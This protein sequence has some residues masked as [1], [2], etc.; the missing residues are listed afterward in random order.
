MFDA[1]SSTPP[2]N[3]ADPEKDQIAQLALDYLD[4]L[5]GSKDVLP[6][7]DSLDATLQQ[8]VLEAWNN[9]DRL[10]VDE[11]LPPLSD[12]PIALALGAVP[13]VL[14]DPRAL[15]KARQARSRRPSSIA[16]SLQQCGWSTTT[17]D[18]F[19]WEQR[20]EQ[21]ALALLAD[22]AAT[23]NVSSEAL[24]H[25]GTDSPGAME[26]LRLDDSMNPFLQVLYSDELNEIVDQWARLQG[27]SPRAA[28]DDLH[29]R[30]NAAAHRG[31]QTLTTRQWKAV[32]VVLLANERARRGQPND[33]FAGT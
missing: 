27:I 4:V 25:S 20:T 21:V 7:I 10:I 11:P 22:L 14:L 5:N 2:P 33:P 19:R 17:S 28:R 13:T 32:L 15:R 29:Q 26:T 24:M 8:K 23:L 9:V 16:E 3:H 6:A 30:F 12:D 31:A 1:S 18:V